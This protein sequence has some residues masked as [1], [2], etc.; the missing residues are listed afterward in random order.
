MTVDVKAMLYPIIVMLVGRDHYPSKNK[1]KNP[2][3][4]I[5]VNDIFVR[6]D[7]VRRE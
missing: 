4:Q 7:K 3:V 2:I 1:M 6:L 5:K